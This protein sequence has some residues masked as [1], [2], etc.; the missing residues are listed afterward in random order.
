MCFGGKS[1]GPS[2]AEMYAKQK[3]NYG[4]LP[5]LSMDKGEERKQV[6]EDVE[7]PKQRYGAER[8]SLLNPYG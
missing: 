4:A 6:F 8:R 2:A 3:V 5:S 7:A 1:S